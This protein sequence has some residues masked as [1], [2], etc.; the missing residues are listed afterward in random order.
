MVTLRVLVSAPF[1]WSPTHLSFILMYRVKELAE[2]KGYNVKFLPGPLSTRP[3]FHIQL[4]RDGGMVAIMYGGHGGKDVLYGE[5]IILGMFHV[6]DVRAARVK[7][8]V[9]VALPA[10]ESAVRLGPE[11]VRAGAKAYVG[12]NAP[13]YAAFDD[14]D[15]P[16]F[17]DWLRYHLAFYRVL[18]DGGTVGEAVDEYRRAGEYY[19]SLYK[20]KV[21]VWANADWHYEAT[22]RNIEAVVLLGE[23]N[24][25]VLPRT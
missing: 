22:R 4:A 14:R 20:S 18:L 12:A 21:G 13:M 8:K 6:D 17:Q 25:R 16:Y 9:V 19:A 1:L 10:C 23:R 24:A 2:R 15:N 7:D 5:D 3:P 11:V